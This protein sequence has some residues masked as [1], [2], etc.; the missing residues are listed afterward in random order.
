MSEK[1]TLPNLFK[2]VLTITFAVYFSM[3]FLNQHDQ[4]G[5]F[6]HAKLV[7]YGEVI[8]QE[9]RVFNTNYFSH[10][11]PD[12][13]FIN[14]HWLTGLVFYP[15]HQIAGFAGLS[16][17]ALLINLAAMLMMFWW[18]A[19]SGNFWIALLVM[20]FAAPMLASRH[21]PRPEM[22]SVL[23][24]VANLRLLHAWYNGFLNRR[25][26][27]ILP[28][29]Q[30]LWANLHILFYFGIFLQGTIFLQLLVNQ[31]KRKEW[32]YFGA[33]MLAGIIACFMNPAFA[34]GVFYPFRIMG[35]IEYAVSENMSLIYHRSMSGQTTGY[36]F[37]EFALFVGAVVLYYWIKNPRELRTH[38]YPALWLLVF[39]ALFIWRIR[40]NV[41]FAYTLVLASTY[42]ASKINVQE[43]KIA[44]RAGIIGL[45]VIIFFARMLPN[46]P[47]DPWYGGYLK[48]GMGVNEKMDAGANYF[49]RNHLQGPIFNNFD[50]GDYLI[51][52]LYPQERVFVD[53]RPEA[54]PRGFFTDKLVPALFDQGKWLA[55]EHE[56][57]FN[58]VFLG[59]HTQVLNFVQRLYYDDGWF[60]AYSDEYTII[61]LRRRPKNDH[62]VRQTLLERKAL[63]EIV[64]IFRRNEEMAR[65]R[66]W[67]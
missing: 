16:I 4:T 58:V 55:L 19:R 57:K 30:L 41:F 14:H 59:Y 23:F 3:F 6:D 49:I 2:V 66:F 37:F 44:R 25:Y 27:W 67:E 61:F 63:H 18:S 46:T 26:L 60:L 9:G 1:L 8:W 47:Y 50:I 11:A 22:F 45:V 65:R 40:A 28:V 54:Y 42:L 48:R 24:F 31:E 17:L 10:T 38:F 20:L 5:G 51:Y 53:S 35:E 21:Q 43:E 39:A 13:P 7:K 52:H 29:M 56:Y 15:L 36:L 33:V 34:Q 32:K 12:Y 64:E 62:L